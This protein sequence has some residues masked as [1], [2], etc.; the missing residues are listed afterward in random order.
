MEQ[1][2]IK[3]VVDE[4]NKKNKCL[5]LLKFFYYISPLAWLFSFEKHKMCV[6]ITRNYWNNL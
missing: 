2:H 1:E 6:E 4:A 3:R 5:G